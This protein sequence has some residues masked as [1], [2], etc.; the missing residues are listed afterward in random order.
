ML[1][2]DNNIIL[3]YQ[4]QG[5]TDPHCLIRWNPDGTGGEFGNE[6]AGLCGGT[7]HGLKILTEGDE[8]FLYHANNQQKLAKTT[9]DGEL[10]WIAEGNFGELG[11]LRACTCVRAWVMS[12]HTSRAARQH[13]R[14][15]WKNTFLLL[16]D[17]DNFHDDTRGAE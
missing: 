16:I 6:T 17:C 1:D 8:Q 3:T 13:W 11:C 12:P 9:L 5:K 14:W 10:V 7:P 2:K 15:L 4:N